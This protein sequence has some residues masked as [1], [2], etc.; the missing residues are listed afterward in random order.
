M[1]TRSDLSLPAYERLLAAHGG[2]PATAFVA[3]AGRCVR[4]WLSQNERPPLDER[5]LADYLGN[6][7]KVVKE[8]GLP[9]PL[10]DS[11]TGAAGEMS[12]DRVAGLAVRVYGG[13]GSVLPARE[14]ET[15]T[16]QL[17]KTCLQP[18]FRDCRESYKAVAAG[19][20]RR[21]ERSRACE[22]VSGSHCVDCPYWVALEPDQH[23]ALL[24][25]E[26]V[27]PD[28]GELA[29]NRALFL[30]EDFRALR[31]FLWQ[32]IRRARLAEHDKARESPH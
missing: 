12:G 2:T 27:A 19:V 28:R 15:V 11:E 8:A 25:E 18:E 20:C 7:W 13:L 32:H 21:Q 5:A 30:P 3:L 17:L 29:R 14:L 31:I 6:M 22:R 24:A 26:W 9:R 23:V 16:R 10:E 1:K 4:R